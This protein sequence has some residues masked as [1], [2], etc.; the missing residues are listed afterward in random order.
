MCSDNN[1]GCE[2]LCLFDGN[3]AT[4]DCVCAMGV[5]NE[6]KKT[7]DGKWLQYIYGEV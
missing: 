7:C 3:E 1:G 5:L 6:N 4:T 2:D